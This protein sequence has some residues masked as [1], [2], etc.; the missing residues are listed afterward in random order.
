MKEIQVTINTDNEN[1]NQLK[2]VIKEIADI[3]K[4]YSC[5]CTL[6]NV[7][8]EFYEPYQSHQEF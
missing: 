7:N 2:E 1:I 3:E 8:L 5:N 4:E 6:I